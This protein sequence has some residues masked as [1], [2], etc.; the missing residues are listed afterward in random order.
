MAYQP[1]LGGVA[2]ASF[3]PQFPGESVDWGS[4]AVT[5]IE[6]LAN[7]GS[8][9]VVSHGTGFFWRVGERPVLVTA[10]HV[11]SGTDPFTDAVISP[12]G[13]IP[14]IVRVYP[15]FS[16]PGGV[17]RV[18]PIVVTLLSEGQKRWVE[19]PDFN[20]LRTDIAAV[21]VQIYVPA[22]QKVACLNDP[23]AGLSAV[24]THV[25]F[26]CSIVGYP[27]NNLAGLRTPIWRRGTIA[28][29]PILPI[30]GKP[31]FLI[32]A[33]TS[34]GFSG[35]PV[36]RR[37]V[38]PAPVRQSD[39]TLQVMVGSIVTTAFIGVYAGRLQNRYYGG[40][41]PFVFYGNRV[42]IIAALA[43]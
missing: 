10:R 19:D 37:H 2:A 29:E 20:Q 42:P 43:P 26:D 15:S 17:T 30:D 14:E 16:Y 9:T 32:D 11:F 28:S 22:G 27:N 3:A 31:M 21:G 8:G 18:G 6:H 39:G 1:I 36:M 25:G 38:G 41:I 5:P 13:Y 40:E 7:D 12:L 33:S 23:D 35:S 24:M 4:L 34:P